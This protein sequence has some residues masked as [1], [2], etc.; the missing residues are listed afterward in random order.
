MNKGESGQN[1]WYTIKNVGTM[2]INDGAT[3]QTAETMP[4]VVNSPALFLMDTLT[5]TTTTLIGA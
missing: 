3:V 4:L 1:S 5:P 2:T